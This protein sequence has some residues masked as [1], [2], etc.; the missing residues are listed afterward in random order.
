MLQP[1]RWPPETDPQPSAEQTQD[2]DE[3][4]PQGEPVGTEGDHERGLRGLHCE[5]RLKRNRMMK[6]S[7]PA[8]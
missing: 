8:I 6:P 7:S 2:D 3:E 4:D 1:S 5:Q